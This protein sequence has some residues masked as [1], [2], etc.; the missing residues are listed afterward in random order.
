[1]Q[2][3]LD[4]IDRST[5]AQARLIEDILDVSSIISG[6]FRLDVAPV[7]LRTVITN[8]IET[9]RPAAT[10]KQIG[11]D[12]DL[13]DIPLVHGDGNRLQQVV[14]NLLSNAIKFVPRGGHISVTLK[15][16]DSAARIVVSDDGPGIEPAFLPHVF[17]RFRQADSGNARAHGGL[18]LGLAIVR[19]LAELHGGSAAVE[20]DG[21]GQGATFTVEIPLAATKVTS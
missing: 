11:I 8:G 15:R 10:A 17:E 6:K 4:S 16:L 18:G 14:W 12:V 19:H 2:L 13:D 1:M 5:Q 7:D 21:R 20:S 3:A 9:L